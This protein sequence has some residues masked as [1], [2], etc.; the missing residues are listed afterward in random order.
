MR[1]CLVIGAVLFAMAASTAVAA[2]EQKKGG[3]MG[4]V[5]GCCFG[6]RGAAAYN[7]GLRAPAM[8]WIDRLLLWGIYAAV[9][10]WDGTTTAD[11]RSEYG[12]RCY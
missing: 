4:G 12:D 3:L 9:L 10:G 6:M 5:Y 2:A 8:E 7:D 11:L 1:K